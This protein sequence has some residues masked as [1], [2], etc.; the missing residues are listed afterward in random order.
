VP[1]TQH[2]VIT[3]FRTSRWKIV[4]RR[5]SDKWKIGPDEEVA[6]VMS[7]VSQGKWFKGEEFV[8]ALANLKGVI[9]VTMVDHNGDGCTTYF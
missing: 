5:L 6:D 1:K 7:K 8:K 3:Q 2:Q 9:C 4:V